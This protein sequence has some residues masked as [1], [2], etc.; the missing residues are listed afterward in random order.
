MQ[1]PHDREHEHGSQLPD[2]VQSW[3][4]CLHARSYFLSAIQTTSLGSGPTF[5]DSCPS[6]ISVAGIQPTVPS[7][8]SPLADCGSFFV[9]LIHRPPLMK[10]YSV[11]GR[12]A[13]TPSHWPGFIT[14]R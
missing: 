9:L 13:W 2:V 11:F 3:R 8:E 4:A 5:P 7:G 14:K 6:L 1:V 10:M 12:C